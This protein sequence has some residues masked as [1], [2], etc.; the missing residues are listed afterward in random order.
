MKLFELINK[1][2]LGQCGCRR[3]SETSCDQPRPQQQDQQPQDGEQDIEDP[4]QEEPAQ[5]QQEPLLG[6][7][8]Q[9]KDCNLHPPDNDEN[10]GEQRV[11]P[12]QEIYVCDACALITFQR[13]HQHSQQPRGEDA[14]SFTPRVRSDK[15][16]ITIL[17]GMFS[18][19]CLL[20]RG[21]F[22]FHFEVVFLLCITRCIKGSRF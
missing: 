3:Q 15:R 2:F 21:L 11:I 10:Q 20:E 9:P 6:P 14:D 4:Q 1:L 12:D 19:L 17:L 18:K 22:W 8:D 13:Q 5:Q 16:S 7:E